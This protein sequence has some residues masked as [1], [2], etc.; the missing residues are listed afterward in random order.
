MRLVTLDTNR[1]SNRASA[2]NSRRV[3]RR[4]TIVRKKQRKEG[5]NNARNYTS[6]FFGFGTR[7]CT[8]EVVAQQSVGLLPN[9]GTRFGS[10]HRACPPA[11]R[12]PMT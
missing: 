5:V 10:F 8:T 4:F 7:G 6:C 1:S 3:D 9:R 11:S 2:T 12:P